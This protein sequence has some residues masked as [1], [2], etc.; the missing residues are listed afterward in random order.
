MAKKSQAVSKRTRKPKESRADIEN[1]HYALNDPRLWDL[2]SDGGTVAD[3]GVTVT[4]SK[5]LNIAAVW[6]AVGMISGDIAKLPLDVYKRGEGE[7][8]EHDDKIP[9]FWVVRRLANDETPAVIFWRVIMAHALLW[10]NGLAFID[11]NGKGEPIGLYNL[12][13]GRVAIERRGGVLY[14]IVETEH[15]DGTPWARPIPSK[16]ILHIRGLGIDATHGCDLLEHA[17]NSFA[18][19]LASEK[20]ASKFFASGVRAGGILELPVGISGPAKKVIEEG[21]SKMYSGQDN[22]FKTVILRDGAK[23]HQTTI[24]PNEGQMTETREEQVRDV[25]RWF[26]VAPSRLGL[27]DSDSYNS[28]SEDKESYLDTTLDIWL[29]IITSECWLK[30]LSQEQQQKDSH[31]FEHNVASLLRMNAV[32]RYQ[33]YSIGIDKGIVNPNEVRAREN[34]NPRPGGDEYMLVNKPINTGGSDGGANKGGSSHVKG[35]PDPGKRRMI[36]RLT[37]HARTKAKNYKAFLE[38]IDGDLL[39][40]REEAA[41]ANLSPEFIPA[42]VERMKRIAEVA[43]AGSL[44]GEVNNLCLELEG[45]A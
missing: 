14:Y 22:W 32:Q 34:M 44:A 36:Y 16:D 10:G 35:N 2:L 21:F 7:T 1:P 27:K 41:T 26:N 31:Y 15:P 20:F 18:L 8:R 9:A 19:A 33:V 3:A 30:M 37:D 24:A 29:V 23:F 13:P 38:W 42:F 5:A 39:T 4:H 28:K 40:H 45:D 17:K 6:Q 25:A 11:R 43:H 12:M